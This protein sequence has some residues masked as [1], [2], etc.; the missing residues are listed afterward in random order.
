VFAVN[1]YKVIK[2]QNQSNAR[3]GMVPG[4]DDISSDALAGRR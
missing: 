4:G 2:I 1:D 3:V